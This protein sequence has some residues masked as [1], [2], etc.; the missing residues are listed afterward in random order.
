MK[1]MGD[2]GSPCR[3]QDRTPRSPRTLAGSGLAGLLI[4][5]GGAIGNLRSRGRGGAI[6][7]PLPNTMSPPSRGVTSAVLDRRLRG[8]AGSMRNHGRSS[9]NVARNWPPHQ[10]SG[11][12]RSL[13]R[14]AT[15]AGVG[16]MADL[17]AMEA[18]RARLARRR[19]MA[20]G[21]AVEAPPTKVSRH[22]TGRTAFSTT[23]SPAQPSTQRFASHQPRPE[24]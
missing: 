10:S 1:S 6:A 18:A 14:A 17:P 2:K 4:H 9:R 13:G 5:R 7:P 15:R 8:A 21:E 19:S 12:R 23:E 11:R 3:A 16:T 20:R 22:R 24:C